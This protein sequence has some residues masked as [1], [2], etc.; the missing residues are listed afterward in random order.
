RRADPNRGARGEHGAEAPAPSSRLPPDLD[1]TSKETLRLNPIIP[2]V[3]RSIDQPTRIGGRDLP[4]G[5]VAA[6]CIYL[7]HRQA[8]TCCCSPLH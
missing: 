4:A 2:E 8:E 6:P 7:A 1:A 3:G 5:V